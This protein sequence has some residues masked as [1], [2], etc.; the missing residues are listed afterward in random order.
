VQN[1]RH[2]IDFMGLFIWWISQVYGFGY[3]LAAFFQVQPCGI[4][5]TQRTKRLYSVIQWISVKY[6]NQRV[7]NLA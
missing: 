5:F 4:G 3:L 2:I 6:K 1:M 7:S